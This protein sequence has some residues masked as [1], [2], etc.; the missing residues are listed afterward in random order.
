MTPYISPD[1]LPIP[2]PLPQ[3]SHP[4]PLFLGF[5]DPITEGMKFVTISQQS[6]SNLAPQGAE[7]KQAM[8]SL[9]HHNW[10]LSISP[11]SLCKVVDRLL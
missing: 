9:T 1:P 4:F 8:G 5:T 2:H 10:V 11:F 3:P 6:K 7:Q